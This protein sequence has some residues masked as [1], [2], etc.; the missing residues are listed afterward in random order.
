MLGGPRDTHSAQYF[1]V[2]FEA[3]LKDVRIV[4]PN[5]TEVICYADESKFLS[6]QGGTDLEVCEVFET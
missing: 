1:L 3:C 6:I 2:C 4:L 5:C